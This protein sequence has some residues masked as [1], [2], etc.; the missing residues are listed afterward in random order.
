MLGELKSLC[1]LLEVDPIAIDNFLFRLHYQV[2]VTILAALTLFTTSRG[3]FTA[4]IDCDFGNSSK[5]FLNT[6]C[7]IHPTFLVERTLTDEPNERMPFPGLSQYMAED[8]L[9]FY[10]YYPWISIA[11]FLQATSLYMPHYIWK[12]WEGGKMKLLAGELVAAPLSDDGLDDKVT[13]LVNYVCSQLHSHNRYAYKYMICELLNIITVVG[14]IWIMNVFIGQ[15]FYFYGIDVMVFNQQREKTSR[16]NPMERLFP[17]ITMCT[18]KKNGTDGIVQNI[19]GACLLTQ[20]AANRNMYF[21]LWFWYHILATIGVFSAICRIITLFSSSLRYHEFQTN[22][23]QNNP[24]DI[25]TVYH[26]LR[27]GD[28]FLLKRLRMNLNPLIY[29]ELIS[30]MA[31]RFD[32]CHSSSQYPPIIYLTSTCV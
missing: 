1:D 15:D 31:E 30:R 10:G 32:C 27:I 11:L 13:S 8:N 5:A 17:T 19:T 3:F 28:W 2:T 26:N 7:Y 25:H 29:K 9:K 21:F 16:L 23:K 14:H 12:Y 24:Y 20:N 22:S 4:Q 6:Y 18:Y